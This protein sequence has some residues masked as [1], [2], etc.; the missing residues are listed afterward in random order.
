M[1][2]A[3]VTSVVLN[4]IKNEHTTFFIHCH[5]VMRFQT[6]YQN[7]QVEWEAEEDRLDML[8]SLTV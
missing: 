5:E 3:G 2:E 7:W 6:S 8:N 1:K 4:R